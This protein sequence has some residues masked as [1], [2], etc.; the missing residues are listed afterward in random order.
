[1]EIPERCTAVFHPSANRTA[2]LLGCDPAALGGAFIFCVVLVFSVPGWWAVLSAAVLFFFLRTLLAQMAAADPKLIP[3]HYN[4]QI[5]RQGFWP[6]KT[7][8]DPRWRN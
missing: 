6:A 1:M 4:S 7:V 2:L 8:R 3:L 5:Y